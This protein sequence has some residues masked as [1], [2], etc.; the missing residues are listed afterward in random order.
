VAENISPR[1]HTKWAGAKRPSLTP[2][3]LDSNNL[4]FGLVLPV[5]EVFL[6]LR[7][8]F[9]RMQHGPLNPRHFGQL[10]GHV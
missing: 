7:C 5:L 2:P 4:L 9:G 8:T 1:T 10:W 6:R 3:W